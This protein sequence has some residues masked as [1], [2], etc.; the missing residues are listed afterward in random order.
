MIFNVDFSKNGI[1]IK[2]NFAKSKT[3]NKIAFQIIQ[4]LNLTTGIDTFN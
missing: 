4:K 1:I 3:L 2:N